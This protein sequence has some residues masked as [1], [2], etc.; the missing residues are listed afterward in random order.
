MMGQETYVCFLDLPSEEINISC[1]EKTSTHLLRDFG[2]E[3]SEGD[4]C[5]TEYLSVWRG[6]KE[7]F[8]LDHVTGRYIL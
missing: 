2:S 1:A 4:W 7:A 3:A 5:L 6:R 8:P